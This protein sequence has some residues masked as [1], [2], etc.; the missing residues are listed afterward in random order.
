MPEAAAK[1]EKLS[2]VKMP[3]KLVNHTDYVR[4]TAFADKGREIGKWSYTACYGSIMRQLDQIE[5]HCR[6]YYGREPGD[7]KRASLHMT[8]YKRFFNLCKKAGLVPPEVRAYT[9]KGENKLLIPRLGWDR[10]TVY[11]SLSLYRH[12]DCHPRM[13]TKAVLLYQKF[14]REGINFLQC[15]HYALSEHGS[16]NSG[17]AFINMNTGSDYEANYGGLN[18]AAGVALAR[19]ARMTVEE[20]SK[21]KPEGRTL[22]VMC[23]LAQDLNPIKTSGEVPSYYPEHSGGAKNGIGTPTYVLKSRESILLPKFTFLYEKPDL[24]PKE[25]AAA[26]KEDC[27]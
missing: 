9:E 3:A 5:V 1:A 18:L 10:H 13:V 19:F 17:H 21:L 22:P 7:L 12:A 4:W 20:R 16:P 26:V 14:K 23:R 24:T 2:D 25:F 15:L 8:Q 27:K 11:T 6:P